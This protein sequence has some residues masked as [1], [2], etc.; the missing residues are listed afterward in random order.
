M[1]GGTRNRTESTSA[2]TRG[3]FKCGSS[4]AAVGQ[5]GLQC[6]D[7]DRWFHPLCANVN[8]AQYQLLQI[9]TTI[10]WYFTSCFSQ[11]QD[12]SDI[13]FLSNT[14]NK[15]AQKLET[16]DSKLNLIDTVIQQPPSTISNISSNGTSTDDSYKFRVK[17]V[18]IKESTEKFN[19]ARQF[20]DKHSIERILSKLEV[21]NA[22]LSDCFRVDKYTSNRNKPIIATSN[23]IWDARLLRSKAIEKK[24]YQTDSI[25]I[26]NE[27]SPKDRAIGKQLLAKRYSIIQSG[28]DKSKIKIRNF[29]LFVDGTEVK[30]DTD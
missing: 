3:K 8:D 21:P 25:L 15:L 10:C 1:A 12:R 27:I 9:L 16:F 20:H 6:E 7:C 28:V 2:I 4:D 23:S 5:T 18:G 14:V 29:K 11:R 13:V 26:V 19:N 17:I 24:V 22:V 30:I